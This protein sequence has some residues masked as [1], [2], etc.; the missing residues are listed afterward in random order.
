MSKQIREFLLSSRLSSYSKKKIW[1][2]YQTISQN[3]NKD[4]VEVLFL[5]KLKSLFPE[6]PEQKQLSKQQHKKYEL[7]TYTLIEKNHQGFNIP[8]A[9]LMPIESI[10]DNSI[11]VYHGTNYRSYESI[12]KNS[13]D[14][15]R[16]SGY[17]GKG[18]YF[19]PVYSYAAYYA[20][21]AF[22]HDGPVVIEFKIIDFDKLDVRLLHKP[23]VPTT[24]WNVMNDCEED[25]VSQTGYVNTP[26]ARSKNVSF[27]KGHVWQ[28][29]CKSN[30]ILKKHFILSKVYILPD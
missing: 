12:L 28:F 5:E 15:S 30:E 16:G 1:E 18:F 24:S 6:P 25:I 11:V 3:Y 22:G 29:L 17:L 26:L 20:N 10:K 8:I 2:C 9:S 21:A 14:A 19:T 23:I 27:H 4:L 13:L 7:L